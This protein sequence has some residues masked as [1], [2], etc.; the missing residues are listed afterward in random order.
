[1]IMETLKKE[2]FMIESSEVESDN[3]KFYCNKDGYRFFVTVK[4]KNK[5]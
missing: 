3:I 2:G 1:M 5:L 4:S